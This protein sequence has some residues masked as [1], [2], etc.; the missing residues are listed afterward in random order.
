MCWLAV[1]D[2][3]SAGSAGCG[4]ARSGEWLPTFCPRV[5]WIVCN[6][7][8]KEDPWTQIALRFRAPADGSQGLMGLP[9]HLLEAAAAGTEGA[10]GA[11]TEYLTQASPACSTLSCVL[12]V[13]TRR[14]PWLPLWMRCGLRPCAVGGHP[15]RQSFARD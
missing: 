13:R 10:Q 11:C 15:R 7:P 8:I 5:C 14:W 2:G 12:V 1:V 3:I 4:G 9:S 6:G